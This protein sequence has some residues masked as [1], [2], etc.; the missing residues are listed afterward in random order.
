MQGIVAVGIAVG[1]VIAARYISLR[2]SVNVLPVGVAMG[3]V[4]ITMV[5]VTSLPVAVDR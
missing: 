3:L 5:F 2:Q 4:V 1:A